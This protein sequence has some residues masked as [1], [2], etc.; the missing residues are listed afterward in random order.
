MNHQ[1]QLE[2]Y[3]MLRADIQQRIKFRFLLFGLLLTILGALLPL[4]LEGDGNPGMLFVYPV[5][6]FFLTMSWIHQSMVMVKI[7]RYLR[8]ELEPKVEGLEWEAYVNKDS[9]RFSGF[10]I[11][12][13]FAAGGFVLFSQ[14]LMLLL[15]LLSEVKA[16]GEHLYMVMKV[17]AI[18][19]S[20]LTFIFLISYN[21][22]K[23]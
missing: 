14:W 21:R 5:L 13:F 19:A 3:K 9:G 2:E 4:G 6:S 20:V 15:G 1:V 22:M 17:A 16:G 11:I 12:G 7:A 18:I 23:R 8:D 10:S